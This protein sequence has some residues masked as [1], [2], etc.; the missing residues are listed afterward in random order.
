MYI[1]L[2]TNTNMGI[3][4][5]NK[6]SIFLLLAATLKII[7]CFVIC[8]C[9]HTKSVFQC[10]V[11][12][13]INSN[14]HLSFNYLRSIHHILND[15]SNLLQFLCIIWRE[16]HNRSHL[17]CKSSFPPSHRTTNQ[18]G[19]CLHHSL[20]LLVMETFKKPEL[21]L[22]SRRDLHVLEKHKLNSALP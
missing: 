19:L 4:I 15:F 2:Y 8:F 12:I 22:M 13:S 17:R 9:I 16:F 11:R 21:D 6:K 18:L 1:C 20:H 14:D 5:Q 3:I 7:S 10:M